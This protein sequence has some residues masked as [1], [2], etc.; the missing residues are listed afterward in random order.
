MISHVYLARVDHCDQSCLSGQ[1]CVSHGK[2]FSIGHY[3][4][5]FQLNSV[6]PAMLTATVDFFPFYA[7]SVTL[8][9]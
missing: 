6:I 4:Q 8:S 2:H 1:L 5:T 7:I 3:A 9:S